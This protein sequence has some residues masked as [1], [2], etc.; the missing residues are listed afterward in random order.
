MGLVMCCL[1]IILSSTLIP[2]A[3]FALNCDTQHFS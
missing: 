2:E 1:K 3:R